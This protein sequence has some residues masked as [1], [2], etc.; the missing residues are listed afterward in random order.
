MDPPI[1]ILFALRPNA[2]LPPTESELDRFRPSL[3]EP[4]VDAPLMLGGGGKVICVESTRGVRGEFGA[5][6]SR[7]LSARA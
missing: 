2:D 4:V 5:D 7:L 1:A 3:V 6:V